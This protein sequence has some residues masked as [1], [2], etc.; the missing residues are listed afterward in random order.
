[1]L[2]VENQEN[3]KFIRSFRLADEPVVCALSYHFN[4]IFT[5]FHPENE[6]IRLE[7]DKGIYAH[8]SHILSVFQWLIHNEGY[9]EVY[10]EMRHAAPIE[11]RCAQMIQYYGPKAIKE[12]IELIFGKAI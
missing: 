6:E 1:M 9:I 12:W 7:T 10:T 5:Y 4:N 2:S 8:T 11:F 3:K